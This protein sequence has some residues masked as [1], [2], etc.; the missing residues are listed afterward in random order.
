M[1][2]I[3]KNFLPTDY[4]TDLTNV[5]ESQGG[6]NTSFPWYFNSRTGA[7]IKDVTFK[8]TSQL[9]HVFWANPREF[10]NDHVSQYWGLVKPILYFVRDKCDI[11]YKTII[12]VKANLLIPQLNFTEDD[13]NLPHV[14]HADKKNYLNIIYFVNDSDGD[15]FIFDGDPPSLTIKQ[16]ITP[17]ANSILIFDGDLYHASSNPIKS[18]KRIV[19]NTNVGM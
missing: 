16:R 8:D 9:V 4:V 2:K 10:Q 3:I 5:L 15:T 11:E 17:E 6:N 12:R 7:P 18:N 14:D 19:I 1:I 13:F